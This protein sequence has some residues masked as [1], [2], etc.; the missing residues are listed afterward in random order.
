MLVKERERQQLQRLLYVTMTRAR[1]TLIFVDDEGALRGEEAQGG[2]G[3]R[4]ELLGVSRRPKPRGVGG[5]ADGI[6][7]PARGGCARSRGAEDRGFIA[8]IECGR[9]S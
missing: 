2:A 5:F 1:R 4:G 7:R 6:N 3:H 9:S 8:A